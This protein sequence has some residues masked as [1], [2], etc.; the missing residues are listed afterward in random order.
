[1]RKYITPEFRV[2][3]FTAI[4]FFSLPALADIQFQGF[5]SFVGGATLDSDESYKGYENKLEYDKDSLYGLQ[6][7]SNLGDGLT[8]TG[9]I[10]ARGSENYKPEFEWMYLTYN[11]TPTMSAKFGRIRTPFYMQ[12]EYLEVGYAYHWIRPP[13]EL[14]AAT[15]TNMDGASLLYN[16]PIGSIDAQFVISLANRKNYSDD[17]DLRVSNFESIIATTGQFDFD[18]HTAK[19]IYAQGD[20]TFETTGIDSRSDQLSTA[21][22][23]ADFIADHVQIQ[24]KQLAFTGAGVDLS[25]DPIKV[26]LEYSVLAFEELLLIPS[27]ETRMLASVAYS[28]D[29]SSVSYSISTNTKDGDKGIVSKAA[30]SFQPTIQGIMN[31]VERDTTTHTI[32]M[33]HDFHDSAAFKVELI[34]SEESKQ[35][36]EATLLRFGVDMIF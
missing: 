18:G 13:E 34:S 32:G 30:A 9:Q 15:I 27:D 28:F 5:A 10:I 2:L 24:G 7:I 4:S 17:P 29:S 20:L 23:S 8:A 6:A 12:S 25:F 33:R 31:A 3:L 21:G 36:T 35:D 11:I 1:M 19:L 14:Y 26:V 22:V 16:L